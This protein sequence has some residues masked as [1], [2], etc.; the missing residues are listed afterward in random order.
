MRINI[1]FSQSACGPNSRAAGRGKNNA[2]RY[3]RRRDFW[4][5]AALIVV[6]VC[7]FAS[8]SLP[9]NSKKPV[10]STSQGGKSADEFLIVD[11][12]LPGQ[13]RKMGSRMNYLSPRRPVKTSAS[14]CEIRGGEYVAFDRANYSTALKIWLPQAKE[15]DPVAQTYVGEIYEKGLGLDP[16]YQF[17]A[18]WYQQAVQ[19]GHSRALI[20][21]G[22]LYEIGLG[23]ERDPRKALNLYRQASGIKGDQLLFAS[24][25][26]STHVPKAQFQSVQGALAAEKQHS[27]ELE[28]DVAQLQREMSQRSAQLQE[29]RAQLEF[30]AEKIT[31]LTSGASSGRQGPTSKAEAELS[32]SLKSL[33]SERSQLQQQVALLDRKN[34][35]LQQSSAILSTQ[36]RDRELSQNKY[37]QQLQKLQQETQRSQQRMLESEQDVAELNQQLSQQQSKQSMSDSAMQQLQLKLDASNAALTQARQQ[38]VA[39][40]NSIKKH[41]Q[42]LQSVSED[43]ARQ[44]QQ[45]SGAQQSTRAEKQR[46]AAE[47]QQREQQLQDTGY[48]LLLAKAALQM[49]R[50]KV[51]QVA[52]QSSEQQAEMVR[53]RAELVELSS[54]LQ[55][56][57]ALVKTQQ[58]KIGEL[59]ARSQSYKKEKTVAAAVDDRVAAL[60]ASPRIEIIEPPVVLVRSMPTVKLLSGDGERQLVGKIL[61]P[62]GILSLSV[63]G[64][65]VELGTN[66]LFHS[67]IAVDVAPKPVNV[68]VVDKKGRRAA[69]AFTF[70]EDEAKSESL[71]K[72]SVSKP[73]SKKAVPRARLKMGNYHA[74]IIGNNDY[75][76]FS[77]LAT[78][79]NDA[80]ET[81][82][83][84]R[85]KYNFKT[86]LLLNADRYT[87]LSAL[88]ELRETLDE[89]D[90]LLI[91]YAGHGM[92]DDS[93]DRGY[94]LPVDADVSNNANWIS[95][96]AI[97]D[98]LN[99]INAKH[100]LVVADSCFSGTLTQS[101]LA[102]LQVDVP[103]E[104]RTEWIKVMAETRARIT[105]TSGGLEPVLDGGGGDHSLFAKAF[106][107]TLRDNDGILEGYSLYYQILNRMG[108]DAVSPI[109]QRE[110]QMPQYAPLHLAGHESGEFFFSPI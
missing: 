86:T 49:E 54:Q 68:V 10:A 46:L 45:V 17:A 69:V 12:L 47:L 39:L 82:R 9:A 40:E 83:L 93:N 11:C 22:H 110:G 56:Q 72:A 38:H 5:C 78:A 13:L 71:A 26:V 103:A 104:V 76:Q 91:Y 16:D 102:R 21:L 67:N 18:Y 3:H 24:S 6:T 55:Q 74:L 58:G 62:A 25:L 60:D 1:A 51:S 28:R 48:Q 8:C 35:Q 89:Q 96:T 31:Q 14:D 42:Q 87:I 92:L 53:Q 80:R 77:T 50:A 100:I 30:T 15:G 81:D 43:Y 33:E 101:P 84:L 88:N 90:N 97:T 108:S 37:Q 73:P 2:H 29:T 75:Q 65:S 61:A 106:L 59:E 94:W 27:T 57:Y 107:A 95:N 23:V 36:L 63:N 19:Q 7:V 4:S 85:N 64:K 52:G 32:Q 66:N 20:N 79:V 44:S 109:A 41:E 98:I 105:L 34:Q 99:V 70:V